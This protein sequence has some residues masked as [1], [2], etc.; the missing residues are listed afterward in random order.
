MWGMATLVSDSMV[1]ALAHYYASQ[2]PAPGIA[3]DAKLIA[4]GEKLFEQGVPER[5]IAPCASCHGAGAEGRSIFPR[6]AGQHAPYLARQLI[7]I[8]KQLRTSP[9]MHGI[10]KD[11]TPDEIGAVAAYLQSK[12]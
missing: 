11:L 9:I 1:D 4:K 6:L 7:V 3:A 8:Q 2:T 10:I 12:S 5:N